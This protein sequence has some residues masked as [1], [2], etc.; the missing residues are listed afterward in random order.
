[1]QGVRRAASE[2][3]AAHGHDRLCGVTRAVLLLAHTGRPKTVEAARAVAAR[4]HAAGIEVRLLAER[5]GRPGH[6]V[7]TPYATGTRRSHGC[8]LVLVLGGD[9]TILRAAELSRHSG[10]PLLGVNLG[11]VGFLAEAESSDLDG[12]VAAR[13]GP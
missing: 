12:T 5:G 9:G 13:A 2:C 1:M 4:L 10:V 6:G 3:R 7:A 8:E 11:R